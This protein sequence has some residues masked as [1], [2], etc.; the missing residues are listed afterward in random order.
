MHIAFRHSHRRYRVA[1]V[2]TTT[3][4]TV[5]SRRPND[6]DASRRPVTRE[7]YGCDEFRARMHVEQ[8]AL[9]TSV[10]N[11]FVRKSI[12]QINH[13]ADADDGNEPT[14]VTNGRW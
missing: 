7:R 9:R 3:T 13:D 8:C 12:N 2:F 10:V 6:D 1:V 14:K 4:R 11:A 5:P